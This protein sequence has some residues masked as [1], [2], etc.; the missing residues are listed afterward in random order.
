MW[1]IYTL[2]ILGC[3]GMV[4][5]LI[6]NGPLMIISAVGLLLLGGLAEVDQM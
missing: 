6:D 1:Q 4:G 2:I 5:V 3:L